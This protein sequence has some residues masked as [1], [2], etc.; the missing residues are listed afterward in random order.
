MLFVPTFNIDKTFNH[1]Q[2]IA[3]QP[4]I[5]TFKSFNLLSNNS[6]KKDLK[7]LIKK[8]SKILDKIEK[9]VHPIVRIEMKKFLKKKK[10]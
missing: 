1:S 2:P 3:P 10:L 8:D 7:S 5:K 9:I 6:L 4:T